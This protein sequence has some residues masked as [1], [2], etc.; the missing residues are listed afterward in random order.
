MYSLQIAI[1]GSVE[2]A[3]PA[4]R[5]ASAKVQQHWRNSK[6][7]VLTL[8]EV[9]NVKRGELRDSE[10][11]YRSLPD[12]MSLPVLLVHLSLS[13]FAFVSSLLSVGASKSIVS[14]SGFRP[15][16]H[17]SVYFHKWKSHLYGCWLP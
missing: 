7:N 8:S 10:R 15:I 16:N 3:F 4:E 11:G 17:Y 13:S 12:K 6:T 1:V 14:F 5:R 2:G 9:E